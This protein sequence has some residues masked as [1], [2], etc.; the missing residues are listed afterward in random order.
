MKRNS[1]SSIFH[2]SFIQRYLRLIGLAWLLAGL[3]AM[4]LPLPAIAQTDY[5][6]TLNRNFGYGNGSDIRGDMTI[7]IKGD[8]SA[9]QTVQFRM[10]GKEMG[11]LVSQAPFE[12]RF[13]TVDYPEGI[14]EID[15]VV[16]LKDG[17]TINTTPRRYNFVSAA[18]QSSSMKKILIPI[19][20]VV[21][22]AM[23]LGSLSQILTGRKRG[24]NKVT[25][26]THRDYGFAGGSICPHCSRPTPRHVWGINLLLGK[27]D[28]CENCGRWSLMRAYP[29]D[30][31]RAAEEAE[32][33]ANQA[34]LPVEKTEEEKLRELLDKSKYQD[35]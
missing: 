31:L 4:M 9:V 1:M 11:A 34:N 30:V 15:A 12:L 14:R 33:A 29:L 5:S 21:V 35:M 3:L 6:L 25:P 18:M 16:T 13:N 7:K 19:L 17:S 22:L 32:A 2:L 28:R 24:G 23:L 27:L 10:D 8:E 26:G 20:V